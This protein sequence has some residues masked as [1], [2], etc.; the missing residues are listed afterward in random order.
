M[1]VCPLAF[2]RVCILKLYAVYTLSA[3]HLIETIL[4]IDL[5]YIKLYYSSKDPSSEL[6]FSTASFNK[7]LQL[8]NF[9]PSGGFFSFKLSKCVP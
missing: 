5:W 8:V 6:V 1:K 2:K 3:E 9:Q 4:C 7:S